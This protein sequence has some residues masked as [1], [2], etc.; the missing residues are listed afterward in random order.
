MHMHHASTAGNRVQEIHQGLYGY[1]I[2]WGDQAL[3]LQFGA[4]PRGVSLETFEALVYMYA[5][6]RERPALLIVLCL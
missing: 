3:V 1:N 4:V 2:G 6:H 5:S